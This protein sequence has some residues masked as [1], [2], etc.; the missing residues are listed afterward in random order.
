MKVGIF[1]E[2]FVISGGGEKLVADIAEALGKKEIYTFAFK[3]D[4]E[5]IEPEARKIKIINLFEYIPRWARIFKPKIRLFLYLYYEMIDIGEID[6]FDIIISSG[7]PPRALITPQDVMHVNYCHSTMRFFYDLWHYYWKKSY[8]RG[9]LSFFFA[10]FFRYIDSIVDSRVDHYFVNS[11]VIKHRLWKYL[12]R[13]STILYPPLKLKNYKFKDNEDFFLHIGRFD[14][15][16]QIMPVINA[17]EKTRS[18]LVLIGEEGNDKK[19]YEYVKNYEGKLIE[20]KGYVDNKEKLD[21]LSRCKAVIYNPKNEDFGIVPVE[22]L[23]AGKP[24]IVNKTGFPPILLKKTGYLQN[25]NGLNIYNGGIVT[26]GDENSIAKAINILDDLEW[27]NGKIREFAK[28]FDFEVFKK[29]LKNKLKEWYN[30]F[31]AFKS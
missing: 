26:K 2:S 17:C 19:T 13:D 3:D 14:K 1:H 18:K 21:L 22:A 7:N 20:F 24:V 15:A 10:N 8:N 29:K 23:A 28:P 9:I 4:E 27:D 11:E 31:E 5:L 12:K 30:N 16:K 25:K 6:D